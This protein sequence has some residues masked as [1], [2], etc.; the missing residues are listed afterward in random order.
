VIK[1][2]HSS[3]ARARGMTIVEILVTLLVISIGL[4]GVAGLHAFSLRN[5]YDALVT[6]HAS[7]LASEILDRMRANRAEA[8]EEGS[9]YNIDIDEDRVPGENSTLADQDVAD[10][11]DLLAQQLPEGDGSIEID[12]ETGVVTITIQWGERGNTVTFQT[13][14]EI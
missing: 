4:L 2:P 10:W 11:L 13:Q 7:A 1:H 6:S 5:N 12:E 8:L 9:L 14:S 3:K